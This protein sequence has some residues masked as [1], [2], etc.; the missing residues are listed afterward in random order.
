MDTQ[1]GMQMEAEVTLEQK[2]AVID[3]LRQQD[4]GTAIA[5]LDTIAAL[6]WR[7]SIIPYEARTVIDCSM[8][9]N[10]D[11]G[12]LVHRYWRCEGEKAHEFCYDHNLHQERCPIDGARL[13]AKH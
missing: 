2:I 13:T 4:N 5:L 1:S 6:G 12:A 8:P 7:P 3:Y 11:H 10:G 9:Y